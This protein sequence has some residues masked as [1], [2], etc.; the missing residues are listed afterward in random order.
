ME[1]VLLRDYES[2][3]GRE[4]LKKLAVEIF[5]AW[6]VFGIDIVPY[7]KPGRYS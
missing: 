4:N 7:E 5:L 1:K 3:R 2:E 6:L